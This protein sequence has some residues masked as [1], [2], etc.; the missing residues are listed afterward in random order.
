MSN[1]TIQATALLELRVALGEPLT[2]G[3]LRELVAMCD[4]LRL[5]DEVQGEIGNYNGQYIYITVADNEDAELIEC[6]DHVPYRDNVYYDLLVAVHE[7]GKDTA[8]SGDC[9]CVGP[10]H[11]DWCEDNTCVRSTN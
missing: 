1:V 2:V 7:C 8:P 6:G 10:K 11:R 9:A 5:E 3:H 4:K